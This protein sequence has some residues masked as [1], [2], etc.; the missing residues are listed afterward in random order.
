ML[1]TTILSVMKYFM[2]HNTVLETKRGH[3]YAVTVPILQGAQLTEFIND[4]LTPSQIRAIRSSYPANKHDTEL[5]AFAAASAYTAEEI[6]ESIP[7]GVRHDRPCY[8]CNL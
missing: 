2:L 5:E 4:N 8:C 3:R 1:K 7:P 6:D